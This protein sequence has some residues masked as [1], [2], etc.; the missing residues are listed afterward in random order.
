[1]AAPFD[2]DEKWYRAEVCDIDLDDY[3]SMQSNLRLHYVDYGDS[4]NRKQHEICQLRTD[5]LKLRF[6]AIEC[7]LARVKPR[8]FI[9]YSFIHLLFI[10][11]NFLKLEESL[12]TL[13]K[14]IIIE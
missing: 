7:S 10:N 4:G 11:P 13:K 14:I 5:F 1:M 9:L 12:Y 8:Y 6:Q 2:F 3:D